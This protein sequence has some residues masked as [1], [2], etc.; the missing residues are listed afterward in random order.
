MLDAKVRYSPVGS[1][2]ALTFDS[3]MML[4]KV[5]DASVTMLRA[6]TA[7]MGIRRPEVGACLTDLAGACV[8]YNGAEV[9]LT[10]A[11]GVG[12]SNAADAADF[13]PGRACRFH[14]GPV[15]NS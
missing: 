7:A 12:T 10:C 3:D 1:A 11:V 6:A 13:Y 9:P 5:Q 2:S 4:E 8:A 15:A 14:Q